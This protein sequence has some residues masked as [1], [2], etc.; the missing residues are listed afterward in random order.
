MPV[1][2]L[3]SVAVHVPLIK[4][5]VGCAVRTIRKRCA[6]RTLRRSKELIIR[7]GMTGSLFSFSV[8]EPKLMNHFVVRILPRILVRLFRA[9]SFLVNYHHEPVVRSRVLETGDSGSRPRMRPRS[10]PSARPAEFPACS[11][12]QRPGIRLVSSLPALSAR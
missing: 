12:R 10:R 8:G 9:G 2:Q 3:P 4:D 5:S 6:R 11:A 7:A 1:R